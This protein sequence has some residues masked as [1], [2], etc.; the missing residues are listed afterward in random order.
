MRLPR[1][2]YSVDQRPGGFH[3]VGAGEKGSVTLNGVEQKSFIGLGDGCFTKRL[4]VL[5]LHINGTGFGNGIGC[6]C[7]KADMQP[8][9]RL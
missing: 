3:F 9:I 1:L 4:G 8:F 5:E 7:L 2:Q 6:F